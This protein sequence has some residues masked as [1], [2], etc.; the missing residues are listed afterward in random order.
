MKPLDRWLQNQRLNRVV[1]WLRPGQKILDL[2]SANGAL[3]QIFAQA[4]PGSLGIDPTLA[5]DTCT[6]GGFRLRRG[7]FPDQMPADAGQFDAI[8]MLAVL[9][10]IPGNQLASFVDGVARYLRTGGWVLL[11]V[12][13]PQVDGV[14]RILKLF[15]LVDGMSLE[16]HHGF[17]VARTPQLFG[18]PRFR[19]VR[20]QQFQLGLNH[21]FVF[22]RTG[23]LESG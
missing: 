14:L 3:F 6:E 17:D 15:R 1:P 16:E 22:E 4:A 20:H 12:P 23:G 13:S 21:L 18:A 9:E 11:T 5:Q 7:L 19:L 2:G 10:H 8:V